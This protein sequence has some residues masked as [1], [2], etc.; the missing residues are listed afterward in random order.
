MD[1]KVLNIV[2]TLFLLILDDF[3]PEK[4]FVDCVNPNFPL[5]RFFQ[6]SQTFGKLLALKIRNGNGFSRIQ[7][8]LIF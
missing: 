4:A 1:L 7:K 3:S 2:K 6:N 5:K 8:V